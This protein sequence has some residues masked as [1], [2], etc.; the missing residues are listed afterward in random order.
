MPRLLS[1]DMGFRNLSYCLIEFHDGTNDTPVHAPQ[2]MRWGTESIIDLKRPTTAQIIEAGARFV[3][4]NPWTYDE[5]D[6][7]VFE[8]QMKTNP[9]MQKLLACMHAMIYAFAANVGN[10]IVIDYVKP[11]L[12]FTYFDTMVPHL[13][14]SP[15]A[16]MTASQ[17][18]RHR[19]RV[20]AAMTE[21]F[22]AMWSPTYSGDEK[23]LFIDLFHETKPNFDLAD[24]L[25]NACAYAKLKCLAL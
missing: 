24:S 14:Q 2:I 16:G 23:T 3:V 13:T 18:Y 25:T 17:E 5:P 19:K 7:V 1:F 21:A 20:A 15:P 10:E 9:K 8:V 4:R 12:K 22:L 6:I 11:K